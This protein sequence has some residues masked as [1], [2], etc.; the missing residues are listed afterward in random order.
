[1]NEALRV[2]RD[3]G[4]Q[5]HRLAFAYFAKARL[6]QSLDPKGAYENF[7]AAEQYYK[8]TP[9]ADLH[10]AHVATHLAAYAIYRGD[11]PGALAV[12]RG[13]EATARDSENAALLATLM[14]LR[15]EALDLAGDR[16]GANRVR[17]DSLGWARYGFGS[18]WAVR[19]K[20]EE[21]HR[22]NPQNG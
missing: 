13:T 17:L 15:A 14:L 6:I 20:L 11:G 16:D 10:R 9:G 8:Q 19:S 7:A 22:L 2:A 5:D 21:I 4:W 1:M 12:L 18:D 3:A